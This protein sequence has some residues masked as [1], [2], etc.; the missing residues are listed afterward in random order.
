MSKSPRESGREVAKRILARFEAQLAYQPD[1]GFYRPARRPDLRAAVP[2]R[3]GRMARLEMMG[4]MRL[5]MEG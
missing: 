4:Q 2:A 5:E 1:A 3:A